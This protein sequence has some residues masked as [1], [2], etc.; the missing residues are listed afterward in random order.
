MELVQLIPNVYELKMPAPQAAPA[1][2]RS[3][4]AAAPA[5]V[6]AGSRVEVSNGAGTPGLARRVGAMLGK[7]GVAVA[8]LTN[9]R[10]FGQQT[11]QI[12]FRPQ[13]AVQAETLRK[14]I[15]G[16]VRMTASAQLPGSTDVRVVL[17]RDTQQA[18]ALRD[19][20]P[21]AAGVAMR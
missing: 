2:Q 13:F 5:P 21:A 4:G 11:T 20:A 18:L 15:D 6:A 9:Q 3:I 16:P 7:Q 12:L 19:A 14:L 10:P 8:R 17:G 1:A